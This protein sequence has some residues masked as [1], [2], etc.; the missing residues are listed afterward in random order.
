MKAVLFTVIKYFIS[1]IFCT[2]SG[3]AFL[4]AIDPESCLLSADDPVALAVAIL[5]FMAAVF[6][7]CYERK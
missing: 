4:L 6:I 1:V 2:V 3:F 5:S 7:M